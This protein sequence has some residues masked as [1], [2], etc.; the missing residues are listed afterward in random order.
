VADVHRLLRLGGWF[1]FS[2][3]LDDGSRYFT[4]A[5]ARALAEH[6]FQVEQVEFGY[7][8]WYS[9]WEALWLALERRLGRGARALSDD[10]EWA[11]WQ[12]EHRSAARRVKWVRNLALLRGAAL[13]VSRAG[14]GMVRWLLGWRWP[15][16][17]LGGLA[18]QLRR[19]EAYVVVVARK[20]S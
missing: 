17:W 11:E 4:A 19:A 12:R 7:D 9:R 20:D 16:R 15:V 5:A 1:V 3:V 8:G 14:R 6:C 13:A 2:T 18:R 10:E